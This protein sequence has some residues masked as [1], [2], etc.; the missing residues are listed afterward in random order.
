MQLLIDLFKVVWL[1]KNSDAIC[2][3]LT[4]LVSLLSENVKKSEKLI[5]IVN[6]KEENI[7]IFWTN[8]GISLKFSGKILPMVI[9][10]TKN[11]EGF[12]LSLKITY[13]EKSQR[14]RSNWS[15]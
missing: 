3:M 4:S 7:H 8:W 11:N 14:G 10:K 1:L 13:L 6:I 2:Q 15:G 12:T 5:K 9:L